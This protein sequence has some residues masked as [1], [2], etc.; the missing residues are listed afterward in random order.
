MKDIN[1][2]LYSKKTENYRDMSGPDD[3]PARQIRACSIYANEAEKAVG[4]WMSG[5]YIAGGIG[6]VAT[7]AGT[8]MGPNTSATEWWKKN[9]NTLWITGGALALAYAYYANQQSN[10]AAAASAGATLALK[11]KDK[12]EAY[13][14]C[15]NISAAYET[16]R[17]A[18]L[19]DLVQQ[20]RYL[21]ASKVEDDAEVAARAKADK[22]KAD[23]AKADKA[24]ADK[25]KADKAK[26]DKAKADKA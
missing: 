5:V 13:R 20:M 22:A 9:R 19:D 6:V 23:K 7:S 2:S 4:K 21:P 8:L 25:A 24:K 1:N 15:L 11:H 16:S 18:A 10:N 26:A 12:G 14:T 3:V 17:G